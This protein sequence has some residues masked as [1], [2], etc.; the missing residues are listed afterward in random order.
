LE[1]QEN[2]LNLRQFINKSEIKDLVLKQENS[3]YQKMSN[4]NEI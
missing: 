2:D 1:K 3:Q 4:G